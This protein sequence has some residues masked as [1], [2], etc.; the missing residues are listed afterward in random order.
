[1]SAP[2]PHLDRERARISRGR[3]RF[4][5]GAVHLACWIFGRFPT[6]VGLW[7]GAALGGLAARLL[8]RR[9]EIALTNLRIAFPDWS[10]ERRRRVWHAACA[11]LGRSFFEFTQIGTLSSDELISRVTV[12][13]LDHME[14]ARKESP[15]GG[16]IVLSAHFGCW[17]LMAAA[18]AQRGFPICLVQRPR[19]NP[20]LDRLLT[21]WRERAG[22]EVIHRGSAARAAMRAL[23][24]GRLVGVA[25]DQNTPRREGIFVNFFGRPA[26]TRDGPA[27]LA[28]RLGVPVLPAFIFRVNGR[29]RHVLR[30]S[31]PIRPA[32]A[33]ED[34][35]EATRENVQRMTRCI[36]DAIRSAP[37]QWNWAHRRWRARPRGEPRVYSSK[38][39]RNLAPREAGERRPLLPDRRNHTRGEFG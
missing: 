16:V 2:P 13:G 39:R 17:E 23:H 9:R 20:H 7:I 28:L 10:D 24:A 18:M 37:D 34:R 4:G 32:A 1:M 22:I 3:D 38:K 6:S 14:A 15:T 27:R 19:G 36:E 5:A 30:I 8:G 35:H 25:L 29:A 11:N 33:A 26:S 21:R 12:E 31:P